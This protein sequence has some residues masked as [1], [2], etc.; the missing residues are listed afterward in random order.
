[1]KPSTLTY[2]VILLCGTQAANALS[3]ITTVGTRDCKTWVN[4]QRHG[5]RRLKLAE[6]NWLYGFISG[7]AMGK[8]EDI[9]KTKT[10]PD[11]YRQW[12]TNYCSANPGQD[13]A[14]AALAL[15]SELERN[16]HQKPR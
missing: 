13:S 14:D 2:A 6:R 8:L 1:M 12:V 4:V 11:T 9:I 16:A 7:F 5:S 15:I 3:V 10:N